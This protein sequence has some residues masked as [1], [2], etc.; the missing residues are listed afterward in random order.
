ML[1]ECCFVLSVMLLGC[2]AFLGLLCSTDNAGGA[3]VLCC[4]LFSATKA[5]V[6][7]FGSSNSSERDQLE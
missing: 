6:I 5:V 2:V 1:C 7:V 3:D 4:F